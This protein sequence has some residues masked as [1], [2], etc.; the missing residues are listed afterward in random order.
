MQFCCL[1]VSSIGIAQKM[2][3]LILTLA[4]MTVELWQCQSDKFQSAPGYGMMKCL[5]QGVKH[6]NN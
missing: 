6:Q 3:S 2:K 4:F 1:H 5:H